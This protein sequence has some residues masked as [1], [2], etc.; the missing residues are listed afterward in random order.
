[1]HL[2]AILLG[3]HS[4]YC[5]LLCFCCLPAQDYHEVL[6]ESDPTETG[7]GVIEDQSSSWRHKA[8][9]C[10]SVLRYCRLLTI[11]N[12][13][14][15]VTKGENEKRAVY[16]KIVRVE[17][18][19]EGS[20]GGASVS[21][22]KAENPIN[23][24]HIGRAREVVRLDGGDKEMAEKY[25]MSVLERLRAKDERGAALLLYVN[26]EIQDFPDDVLVGGFRTD[27][28][29]DELIRLIEHLIKNNDRWG[30]YEKFVVMPVDDGYA[31]T[32]KILRLCMTD[33]GLRFFSIGRNRAKIRYRQ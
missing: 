2:S 7:L 30:K 9:E 26:R 12:L 6:S 32:Y 23:L 24:G 31:G 15:E 1:M 3:R 5:V 18:I 20:L 16:A 33:E 29:A 14:G 17:A 28:E 4:L 13:S 8:D 11:R 22:F 27:F 21:Q 10:Y 25:L 19:V